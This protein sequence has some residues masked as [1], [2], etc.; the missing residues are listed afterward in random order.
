[1]SDVKKILRLLDKLVDLEETIENEIKKERD[2]KRRDNFRKGV[3]RR[4]VSIIRD[5]LF[6]PNN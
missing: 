4:D 5:M 6:D 1:M 3:R 2:A